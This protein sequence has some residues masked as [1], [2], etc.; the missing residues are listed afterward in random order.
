MTATSASC[1]GITAILVAGG[2]GQRFSA[3]VDK[4]LVPVHPPAT[5]TVLYH[6]AH[7]LACV[8]DI[9]QLVVVC[10][11]TCQ[12]QY[13]TW[14]E[15]SC[16]E[17][18]RQ[19]RQKGNHPITLSWT[20]AGTT[21]RGSV[22][23]GLQSLNPVDNDHWV[24][25]HD[26]ARPFIQPSVITAM[27]H[28]YTGQGALTLAHRVTDTIK[29]QA[30]DGQV[31]TLPREQLWAV[32]TP[33]LFKAT[34]LLKAHQTVEQNTPVTDDCQ[35]LELAGLGHTQFFEHTTVNTKITT[36]GDTHR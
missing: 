31:I 4:L 7:A 2:S 23:A 13:A 6:S 1:S 34:D 8:S 25:I 5:E 30:P 3:T 22:W 24:L 27:L 33:Q 9:T 20:K 19:R 26:A 18:N 14:V 35:L 10:R 28:A 29:Q 11:A 36:P 32:E 12:A 17:A 21:R 15:A 16:A